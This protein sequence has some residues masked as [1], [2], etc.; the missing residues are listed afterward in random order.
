MRAGSQTVAE[1]AQLL[2]L[3]STL[4][5]LILGTHPFFGGKNG[6]LRVMIVPHPV[7][8]IVRWFLPLM[9]GGETRAAPPGAI[10]LVGRELFHRDAKPLRPRRRIL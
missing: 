4:D 10:G 2:L 3:A 6:S 7:P 9:Y 8:S 5:R 1:G